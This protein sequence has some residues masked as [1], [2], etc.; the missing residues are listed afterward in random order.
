VE[1]LTAV[2]TQEAA[3]AVQLAD[4]FT[5][6]IIA[7]T[8]Q[9]EMSALDLKGI[10][11]RSR[12]L[13]ELRMSMTRPLDDSKK[14]IVEFFKRPLEALAQAES[15]IKQAMLV[16]Q[17]KQ[18]AIRQA[19]ENRL[20]EIQRQ[21]EEKLRQDAEAKRIEEQKLN[22]QAMEAILKGNQAEAES[23]IRKADTAGRAA[24][25]NVQTAGV[26]A[27]AAPVVEST[28]TKPSG[29]S[30]RQVWGFRVVDESLVPREFMMVDE[31]KLGQ[32]AR[33]MKSSAKVAGV[34]FSSKDIIAA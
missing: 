20:R 22:D 12:E 11:L 27:S 33:A 31:K 6:I 25:A 21:A 7:S 19:E 10:K 30:T 24:E 32:Y 16:W 29:I 26:L 28:L 2:A 3:K 15:I 1:N 14:R 18:E 23:L 34:E 17:R 9:Y 4:R 13:D 8:D 5:D